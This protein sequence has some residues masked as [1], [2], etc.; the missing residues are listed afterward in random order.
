[1]NRPRFKPLVWGSWPP[2]NRPSV[3][4]SPPLDYPESVTPSGEEKDLTEE[5]AAGPVEAA[6]QEANGA[7][8]GVPEPET[9][10][11]ETSAAVPAGGEEAETAAAEEKNAL[12]PAA[13]VVEEEMK[14]E[15][16]PAARPQPEA[17]AGPHF[18]PRPPAGPY[19]PPDVPGGPAFPDLELARAYIPVQRYGPT[20]T[21]AQALERG[22]LFPDLYRPYKY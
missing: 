10:E 16:E 11:D 5:K 20:Y 22:T 19:L 2:A 18:P 17:P 7:A 13:L 15:D 8:W 12:G 14:V 3:F 21:P 9:W 1:M 4:K 6:V